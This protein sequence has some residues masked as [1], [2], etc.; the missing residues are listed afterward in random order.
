MRF[1]MISIANG[2]EH[3]LTKPK[4]PWSRSDQ[5]TVRGTD[6]QRGGQVGRPVEWMNRTINDATVK[7]FH[8]N[9]HDP[10]RTHLA[11]VFLRRV[12]IPHLRLRPTAQDA[13]RPLA[14]RIHLQGPDTNARYVHPESDP[15]E[16]GAEQLGSAC[17]AHA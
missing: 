13:R 7:R 15:P 6:F 11:N 1:D 8:H 14:Q 17:N 2:I 16:A 5:K 4:H 9:N 10:L 3:R 12:N